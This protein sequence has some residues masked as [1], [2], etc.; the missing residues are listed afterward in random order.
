[1]TKQQDG[2]PDRLFMDC[3][4]IGRR[5]S[6]YLMSR[7]Q[8]HPNEPGY[9]PESAL[10]KA[11]AEARASAFEEAA[12]HLDQ[13]AETNCGYMAKEHFEQIAKAARSQGEE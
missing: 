12:Y 6:L 8:M 9:V 2:V 13:L 11:V 10:L 7:E 4:D 3:A 5:R 1:M